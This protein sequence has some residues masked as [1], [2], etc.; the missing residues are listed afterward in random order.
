MKKVSSPTDEWAPLPLD[1]PP[2]W[3]QIDFEDAF[4]NVSL[5]C[6]KVPQ[7]EYLP[8][9]TIPI[10]DQGANLIGGYTNDASKSIQPNRALI[11]F[12]DHTKCFKLIRF[13]FAPGADGVKVLKPITINERFAYYAC[14]ALRIPNRGY[15]RHYAFLKKSKLPL[16]PLNEQR[17]IVDKIEELYS[18]LDKGVESLKAARAQLNAYRQAVLKHAFEGKLTAQWREENKDKLDTPEQLLA[19]IKRDRTVR[20]EARLK[21]WKAAV[22]TWEASGKLGEKPAK[23][24]SFIAH[25][26]ISQ[27][28]LTG[29]P[30]IPQSWQYVRLAEIA[31]IGSGMSVSK[32]RKLTDP[33]EIPYLSVANVQR[34]ALNLSTVKTMKIEYSQLPRLSLERWDVLFNEGG[35][36]DKLGRGWVWE[37]QIKPCITQNHVF[38]ARPILKSH[39]HSKLISHWGNTFGQMYFELQGKQ[40]TN[41]A[42]INKTVL[43]RFPIPLPPIEEQEEIIQRL[44]NQT[45]IIDHLEQDVASCL[46]KL[47]ALRQS[48]L[49]CA[50]KGRLVSQDSRD[51]PATVLLKRIRAERELGGMHPK[52]TKK[53]KRKRKTAA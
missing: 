35:D 6:L 46:E 52:T 13:C 1:I 5:S 40:T 51:E 15:S 25:V 23:P 42:S 37:S 39:Q 33:V 31:Y 50:F 26:P 29:L 8:S 9:G 36:R 16:A 21:D 49:K 47:N 2:H 11:V 32:S 27:S 12:G 4:E 14:K 48:I 19:R 17:R 38:H 20:Y 45:E 22:K 41:L 44:E 28:E 24:A 53:S 7:K 10:I 30:D 18:E 3:E 43:S 34:G